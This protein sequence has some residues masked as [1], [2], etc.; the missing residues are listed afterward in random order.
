[1]SKNKK[2]TQSPAIKRS[3]SPKEQAIIESATENQARFPD[4]AIITTSDVP[5]S[6]IAFSVDN[7]LSKSD[8]NTLLRSRISVAT[9]APTPTIAANTL[10]KLGEAVTP[11][12]LSSNQIAQKFDAA[13]QTM[14]SLQPKDAIESQLISQLIALHE[15]GMHW[16]SLAIKNTRADFV[17]LLLNGASK[18]LARHHETLESL[19]R[20]RRQGEQRVHVEHVHIH[21]GAQAIVGV[22]NPPHQ[23][24][25]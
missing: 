14:E 5:N 13:A 16:L 22:V 20:Y 9:G 1:M 8:A 15:H 10:F 21:Q 23:G 4:T 6:S 25:M 7:T 2:E 18:V 24:G 12:E 3:L 17:N 19:M 11:S